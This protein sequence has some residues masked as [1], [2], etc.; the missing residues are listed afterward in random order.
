MLL[1]IMTTNIYILKLA[2]DCWYIGRTGDVDKRVQQHSGGS[3][4]AWTRLHKP[5]GLEKVI[6]GASPFDE[7]KYTKEY[8]AKYGIDKVRGGSYVTGKLNKEQLAFLQR[9]IWG[10]QDVCFL[11]GGQH[12]VR[13]CK[14]RKGTTG[15]AK[16]IEMV[17]ATES[18]DDGIRLQSAEEQ[19]EN[20][21]KCRDAVSR[22][23][24]YIVRCIDRFFGVTRV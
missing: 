12:F 16:E 3:G 1:Y 5:V 13:Y 18:E 15:E 24:A 8:M 19:E 21:R 9:E 2:D 17:A 11:C 6:E 10:A 22:F 20:N 23:C 4:S 14:K 7:D